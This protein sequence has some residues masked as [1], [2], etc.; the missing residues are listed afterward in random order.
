MLCTPGPV[1]KRYHS[2]LGRDIFVTAGTAR[3][4]AP[5]SF[6]ICAIGGGAEGWAVVHVGPD[7]DAADLGGEYYFATPE[8]ALDFVKELIGLMGPAPAAP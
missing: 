5:G 8:E 1:L 4:L 7:G 6:G 3:D 2:H